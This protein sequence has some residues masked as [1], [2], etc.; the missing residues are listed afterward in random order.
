MM[1]DQRNLLLAVVL[2]ITI[3]VVFQMLYGVPGVQ[4]QPEP[5]PPEATPPSEAIDLPKPKAPS[6]PARAPATPEAPEAAA[7]DREAI[8]AQGERIEIRSARLAGSLAL[9]GARIDDITLTDYRETLEPDSP[10]I[11][12]LEPAATER[13]YY[14][15]FGWLPKKD[16]APP[17][18]DADT[19]WWAS[20]GPLSPDNPLTLSWDN[21]AGLRFERIYEFDRDYML[22]V[23]QRVENTGAEPVTL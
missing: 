9:T 11:V 1:P 19:E 21:G 15:E 23:T 10:Q 12:L 2:S 3:I 6:G 13:A 18:P 22:T 17:L 7:A 16:E 5:T 20:E 14:A 8:L 4:R